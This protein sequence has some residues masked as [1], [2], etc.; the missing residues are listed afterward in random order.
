VTDVA[1]VAETVELV[2]AGRGSDLWS[3]IEAAQSGR[4]V[5]HDEPAEPGEEAVIAGLAGALERVIEVWDQEGLHNK[6]PLLRLIDESLAALAPKGLAL[7]W[8]CV[9]RMVVLED[10]ADVAMPVA[11]LAL[12]R[13]AAP[14][15]R[16][17]MP[18]LLDAE[19]TAERDDGG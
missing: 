12:S 7:Y 15:R 3:A 8:G 5:V 2:R 14:T 19:A 17:E 16:I 18:L 4:I 9:E 1:G 6:A 13:S 10:G 11:V